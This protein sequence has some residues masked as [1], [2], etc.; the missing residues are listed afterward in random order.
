[1]DSARQERR[2]G[3]AAGLHAAVAAR[4][5]ERSPLERSRGWPLCLPRVRRADGSQTHAA[6]AGVHGQPQRQVGCDGRLCPHPV[7][8]ARLR[9]P[10][11]PRPLRR[12]RGAAGFGNLACEPGN[13][14][15]PVDRLPGRD[16]Q[17]SVRR[18]D[19]GAE[20]E[21]V[22]PPADQSRRH[23]V[24]FPAPLA[25]GCGNGGE[26]RPHRFR[27]APVHRQPGRFGF[28]RSGP[29][30]EHVAFHLAGPETRLCV[31]QTRRTQSR[32]LPV[33]GPDP[34]RRDRRR[35]RDA[36][37]RA[38][39]LCAHRRWSGMDSERHVS[40][41]HAPPDAVLGS[42]AQRAARRPGPLPFA[43]GISGRMALRSAP[44]LQPRRAHRG[45]RFAPAA[46]GAGRSGCWI[47]AQSSARTSL[48]ARPPGHRSI[49]ARSR[50]FPAGG[51]CRVLPKPRKSSSRTLSG[52]RSPGWCGR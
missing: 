29:I 10:G 38:Q 28:A 23:A 16:R 8:A 46:A 36:G 17:D 25:S 1:M 4:H 51:R 35:R 12:S 40:R 14:G 2:V 49:D 26:P 30:G 52:T 20:L 47:S 44:A 13:G 6:Q 33:R 32:I 27:D 42:S 7:H 9:L 15:Q 50:R 18:P 11:H 19:A 31:D 24:H 37:E 5:A 39:Y 43:A 21:L 22:Q 48:A 41:P 3:L 34:K 45:H